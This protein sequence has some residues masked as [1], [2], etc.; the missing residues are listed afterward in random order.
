MSKKKTDTETTVYEEMETYHAPGK[1]DSDSSSDDEDDKKIVKKKELKKKP[2][3]K[4]EESDDDSS[5]DSDSD[6]SDSS[7]S[8]D[9][10]DKKKNN[11]SDEVF[12]SN[13]IAWV[14]SDNKQFELK[15][16]IKKL[17]KIKK[18]ANDPIIKYLQDNKQDD[19]K[20][21]NGGLK[22]EK[23]VSKKTL[24]ED[25]LAEFLL[26]ENMVDNKQLAQKKAEKFYN[27]REEVTKWSLKRYGKH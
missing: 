22:L 17:N 7:D 19:V 27:S 11:K 21:P 20:I 8:D 1:S 25:D 2:K 15:N 9:D 16:E 13:V 5:S 10:D 14:K 4:A 6:S 3:K 26:K 23:K 24:K 12:K 18:N